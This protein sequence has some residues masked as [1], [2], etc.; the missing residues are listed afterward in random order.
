[1]QLPPGISS[2]GLGWDGPRGCAGLLPHA[3]SIEVTQ[4]SNQSLLLRPP[5]RLCCALEDVQVCLRIIFCG[6][7]SDGNRWSLAPPWAIGRCSSS[8]RRARSCRWAVAICTRA[9]DCCCWSMVVLSCI[10]AR[11]CSTIHTSQGSQIAQCVR[12]WLGLM[13]LC[14]CDGVP[15]SQHR[16]N[17]HYLG[18][19][20]PH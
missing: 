6:H 1:M 7:T 10:A 13:M 16:G 12:L 4:H 9:W 14:Q 18:S 15:V 8:C 3:P 11:C 20:Y 2:S 17:S 5:T 19:L